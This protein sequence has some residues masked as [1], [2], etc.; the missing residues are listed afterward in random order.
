MARILRFIGVMLPFMLIAFGVA[1]PVRMDRVKKLRQKGLESH[2]LREVAILCFTAFLAGLAAATVVPRLELYQGSWR[3]AFG[4]MG[5][6]N[7]IPFLVI[8]KTIREVVTHQNTDYFWINF[9]GNIVM[10]LPIGFGLALLWRGWTAKKMAVTGL[11]ITLFIELNQLWQKR[12]CDVDDLWLN[13]SGVM[14]GYLLWRLAQ[15]WMP[16]FCDRFRVKE[17]EK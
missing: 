13:L 14:L 6:L 7:L 17:T 16:A 9:V 4:Q 3:L 10:F 5:G 12:G 1:I 8:P 2:L 11:C 15:R